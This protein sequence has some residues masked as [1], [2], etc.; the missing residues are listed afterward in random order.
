MGDIFSKISPIGAIVGIVTA[1]S[2]LYSSWSNEKVARQNIETI[3][4]GF[5]LD[6]K[7]QLVRPNLMDFTEAQLRFVSTKVHRENGKAFYYVE[8]TRVDLPGT[9]RKRTRGMFYSAWGKKIIWRSE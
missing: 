5:V 8:I 7:T 3:F 1:C 4:T 9:D 2:K 6:P